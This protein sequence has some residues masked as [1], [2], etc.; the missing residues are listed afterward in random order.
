[1]R[2]YS[3]L[4]QQQFQN[5]N[6]VNQV[7]ITKNYEQFTFSKFNRNVV[8]TKQFLAQ[9][10]RGF[11]SPII[12]NENLMVIDGQH[13]LK[14]S[15]QIGAPILYMIVN[16]LTEDDV[17]A[18]NTNQNKWKYKDFI[19]SYANSGDLEYAKLIELINRNTGHYT[20]ATV[21]ADIAVDSTDRT[22]TSSKLIKTGN[23]KFMNYEKLVEFLDYFKLFKEKTG[24]KYNRT[25]CYALYTLF[26]LK[27]I[28]LDRLIKKVIACQ[29]S[30]DLTFNNTNMVEST[31]KMLEAYNNHVKQDSDNYLDFHINSRGALVIESPK[32]DWA[33]DEY[34][35][36]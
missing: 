31:R 24:I 27:E 30:D 9:A 11:V 15:E 12:V 7:F 28:D 2:T 21:I 26:K 19:E 36:E 32:H 18:M 13:R 16:G 25:L 35:K 34:E 33:M 20:S 5:D 6:I 10:K 17:R 8:I 14:A 4:S 3:H 23:F 22:I 29:V 1:M